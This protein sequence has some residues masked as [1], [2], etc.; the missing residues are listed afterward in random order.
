MAI[1]AALEK[2]GV[3]P[4][5]IDEVIMGKIDTGMVAKM[6]EKVLQPLL[7]RIPLHRLGKPS[8]IAR[9]YLFLASEDSDYINGTVLEVNGGLVL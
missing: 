9:A 8:D 3:Y 5:Q 7:D 6:P 4:D 1:R 2:A